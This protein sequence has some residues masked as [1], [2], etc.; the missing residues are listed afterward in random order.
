MLRKIFYSIKPEYRYIVR[1][2]YY[3]PRDIIARLLGKQKDDIPSKGDLFTGG[4]NFEKIGEEFLELFISMGNLKIDAQVLEIGSG[5]GRMARPLRHFLSYSGS[6]VG[7]DIIKKGIDWS[8]EHIAKGRDNF[9][10]IHADIHNS[11]YNSEGQKAS[12]YSFPLAEDTF[13]FIFLTSV[14]THML[15]NDVEHYIAE[16]KRMLKPNGRIFFTSFVLDG[17][18]IKA[19]ESGESNMPFEYKFGS[20]RSSDAK[21]LE[22][23]I[24]ISINDFHKWFD[25]NRLEVFTYSKGWWR[26]KENKT[27]KIDKNQSKYQD[28]FVLKNKL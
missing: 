26:V 2:L 4:G 22:S 13:D 8:N 18:S 11:L 16:M 25:N 15:P 6:Y 21:V 23:N 14:F 27:A 12:E 24:A 9:K 7:L 19:I 1:K 10:F 3:L 20:Y 28:I 5:L 17:G